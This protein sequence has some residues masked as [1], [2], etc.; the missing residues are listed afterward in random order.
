MRDN[1]PCTEMCKCQGCTNKQEEA[2]AEDEVDG[3]DIEEEENY[4]ENNT[5]KRRLFHACLPNQSSLITVILLINM[6]IPYEYDSCKNLATNLYAASSLGLGSKNLQTL[7][8]CQ[9]Y[10]QYRIFIIMFL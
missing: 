8:T 3:E 6:P 9:Q 10:T 2:I 4:S 7:T 5:K 1:L